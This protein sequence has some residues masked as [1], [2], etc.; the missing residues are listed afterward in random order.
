MSDAAAA[1]PAKAPKKKAGAS[2]AKKQADH[3]K[4]SDMIK[5]A[6]SSLKVNISAARF[7][8]F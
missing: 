7:S 8:L 3:P 6:L 1:A 2:K 4:Y 5:A